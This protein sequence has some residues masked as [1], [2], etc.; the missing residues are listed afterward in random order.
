MLKDPDISPVDAK[1]IQTLLQDLKDGR[2]QKRTKELQQT[3]VLGANN[4]CRH[5]QH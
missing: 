4:C 3:K 5:L 1:P 2:L